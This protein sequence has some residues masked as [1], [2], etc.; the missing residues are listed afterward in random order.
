MLALRG[1]EGQLVG[2]G[3]VEKVLLSHPSALEVLDLSVVESIKSS[4]LNMF[5]RQ[6]LF[7]VRVGEADGTVVDLR[8]LRL[9]WCEVKMD[10]INAVK[11]TFRLDELTTVSSTVPSSYLSDVM[12]SSSTSLRVLQIEDAK[13]T[14]E[15]FDWNPITSGAFPQL[16]TPYLAGR[17]IPPLHNLLSACENITN[18]V[19]DRYDV[20]SRIAISDS[21]NQLSQLSMELASLPSP[22]L[23]TLT[24]AL[25]YYGQNGGDITLQEVEELIALPSM[26]NAEELV[27][28]VPRGW[29]VS[30]METLGRNKGK[31]G[32]LVIQVH[33][34]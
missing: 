22:S 32:K 11:P 23:K 20:N 25:D 5:T 14:D 34:W 33:P 30:D 26:A 15:D 10:D 27:L 12:A 17:H 28:H 21:T 9:E 3:V 6:S 18:L 31:K 2:A 8:K 16:R 7:V 29:A 19:V 24:L 4:S 13:R 1:G